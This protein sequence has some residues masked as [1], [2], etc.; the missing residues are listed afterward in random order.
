[1][2]IR[3]LQKADLVT[4]VEWMNHPATY[5]SMHYATPVLLDNT[6]R[7][8]EAAAENDGRA[9]LTIM[10]GVKYVLLVA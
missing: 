4:R 9:D 1:M 10:G 5:F 3:R 8:Y 6:Y 7:W 2:E